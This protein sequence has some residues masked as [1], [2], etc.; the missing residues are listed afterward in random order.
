[1]HGGHAEMTSR[2]PCD[3]LAASVTTQC[4]KGTGWGTRAGQG[5]KRAKRRQGEAGFRGR[6]EQ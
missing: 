5:R 4:V 6:D 3:V 2:T 1:V